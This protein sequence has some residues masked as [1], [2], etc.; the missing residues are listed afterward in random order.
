MAI[1]FIHPSG[2]KLIIGQE[3]SASKVVP[4]TA[5]PLGLAAVYYAS[6]ITIA[7]ANP[8]N[9]A[10]FDFVYPVGHAN[11]GDPVSV[12]FRDSCLGRP[13]LDTTLLTETV[14]MVNDLPAWSDPNASGYS[15]YGM[16][17]NPYLWE[18]DQ[19]FDE[20]IG[21]APPSKT[22]LFVSYDAALNVA[23]SKTGGEYLIAPS[24]D[25]TL[26]KA[27]RDT[28]TTLGTLRRCK[29]YIPLTWSSCPLVDG[30]GDLGWADEVKVVRWTES[31][32]DAAEDK[33]QAIAFQSGMYDATEALANMPQF[34]PMFGL[35]RGER[36]RI[37]LPWHGVGP[38]SSQLNYG[39][40]YGSDM[41]RAALTLHT[42]LDWDTARKPILMNL[43]NQANELRALAGRGWAGRAGEGQHHYGVYKNIIFG[44]VTGDTDIATNA[45]IFADNSSRQMKY[46]TSADTS[47]RVDWSTKALA[48]SSDSDRKNQ[49]IHADDIGLPTFTNGGSVTSNYSADGEVMRYRTTTDTA[50]TLSVLAGLLAKNTSLGITGFDAWL[51]GGAVDNTNVKLAAVDM[52]DIKFVRKPNETNGRSLATNEKNFFALARPLISYSFAQIPPDQFGG[53]E[54]SGDNRLSAGAGKVVNYDYSNV[55]VT[56]HTITA[57]N[58]RWSQDQIQFSEM[59]DTTSAGTFDAGMD[60]KVYVQYAQENA[61]GRA[62]W[63]NNFPYSTSTT[64]ERSTITVAGGGAAADP[65]FVEA[66]KL[67]AKRFPASAIPI[68]DEVPTTLTEDLVV[69]YSGQGIISA[70]PAAT[71]TFQAEVDGVLI[72]TPVSNRDYALQ[73]ADLDGK[74]IRFKVIAN[75]GGAD[76]VAWTGYTTTFNTPTKPANIIID[77][78]FDSPFPLFEPATFASI[79]VANAVFEHE[80]TYLASVWQEEGEPTVRETTSG[81]IRARKTAGRVRLHVNLAADKPLTP[82][83]TYEYEFHFPRGFFGGAKSH[84][85]GVWE[86]RLGKNINGTDILANADDTTP[87][88]QWKYW[89]GVQYYDGQNTGTMDVEIITGTFTVGGAETD[90]D[91]W[92]S[93]ENTTTTGGNSMGDPAV[94]YALVKIDGT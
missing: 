31:Q 6:T 56:P 12:P 40:D 83:V 92:L 33:F 39:A 47:K 19:G 26:V 32:V 81:N 13:H 53:G 59:L 90:L 85:S 46:I 72:G 76:V 20:M 79:S 74:Q 27:I 91:L 71:V 29:D 94:S 21:E 78:N 77:T 86:V 58:V 69:L 65:V 38:I 60:V 8:A 2:E 44:M 43:M 17:L 48:D 11:A 49:P 51:A 24:S 3:V 63:S 34:F 5:P 54:N 62:R 89:N 55:V 67:Y 15:A 68:Y 10:T 42:D 7:G 9:T 37:V 87:Q 70:E 61:Y 57:H 1:S 64:N 4:A 52:M 80:A 16:M 50:N 23:P 35:D 75:N 14:A 84:R 73:V 45:H 88:T 82:G 66:P 93:V 36:M 22:K 25:G 28:T 18:T 30:F 41:A